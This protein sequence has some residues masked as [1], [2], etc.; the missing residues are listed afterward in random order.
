[1]LDT[2]MDDLHLHQV[3]D[4]RG[5][6][7]KEPFE[8]QYHVGA[9]L[10]S[11]GFGSV[12][13]GQ[14]IVDGLQVAIKKV[15]SDRVQQWARVPDEPS[16][17]PMEIVL[18]LQLGG[19]SCSGPAHKGVI[20]MLDWFE[21][22]GQGF[23]IVFERPQPC[24]D[25]FDFITERG[26]LEEPLAQRF[27]R[28]IVEALRFCQSR[29]VVHRDVKDENVLVDTRTGDVKI[30]DFGSGALLKDS[31][32]TDFEGTRVYSPPEWVLHQRYHARP[33]T[34]WSL[35]VLLFDMVC[36]DI[37]FERDREIVEAKPS[38]TRRIS[39]ECQSLIRWCLAYRP[40]DRPSLEQ[41]LLHPW[42]ETTSDDC[43][44]LQGGDGMPSQSSL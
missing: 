44:D 24:Q 32:Y 12:F 13:A 29:G 37:P 27:M 6:T 42:M 15:S 7:A 2:R 35:G 36:G 8:K 33:L 9:L 10:G 22:P 40:E 1:M 28:Q 14:R 18:L 4:V 11:G 38:F 34:V 21:I 20:R 16:P 17:V 25:L 31:V 3:N 39:K 26:A 5:K 43:G 41:I 19:G 23:L 30:I